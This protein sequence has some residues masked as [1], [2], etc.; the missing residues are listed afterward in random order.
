MDDHYKTEAE[1]AVEQARGELA[2]L[3]GEREELDIRISKQQRRLAALTALVDDSEETDRILELNLGG[4]T[5]AIRTALRAAGRRGLT[6]AEITTRLIQLYFPVRSYKNFRASLNTVLK[7]LVKAG[8]VR[9]S[10]HDVQEG[11]DESVYQ[12]VGGIKNRFKG[13]FNKP[14]FPSKS[15]KA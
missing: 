9:R 2:A 7:R 12:W 6:P 13:R 5:D 8:E 4:V 15:W 14:R 1:Q 3:F 11:R 10:I